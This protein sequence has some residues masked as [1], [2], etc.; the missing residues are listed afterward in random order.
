M[1]LLYVY[2]FTICSCHVVLK[3]YLLTYFS[4]C[5]PEIV[6]LRLSLGHTYYLRARDIKSGPEIVSLGQSYY[7]WARLNYLW[8]R[9][10]MLLLT[11]APTGHRS[12]ATVSRLTRVQFKVFQFYILITWR[13]PIFFDRVATLNNLPSYWVVMVSVKEIRYL[14]SLVSVS[15]EVCLTTG[16]ATYII[17]TSSIEETS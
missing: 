4:N 14:I 8:P 10:N 2:T 3:V 7:V 6:S 5:R 16:V 15:C 9:Y 13:P 12:Y 1:F 11:M 17:I